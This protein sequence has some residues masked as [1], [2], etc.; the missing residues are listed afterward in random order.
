MIRIQDRYSTLIRKCIYFSVATRTKNRAKKIEVIRFL[1][2]TV[3]I[4]KCENVFYAK[5]TRYDGAG[6][7]VDFSR[8]SLAFWFLEG[9]E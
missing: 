7:L 8:F 3:Y 1:L 6:I 9:A 5:V 4:V 2:E